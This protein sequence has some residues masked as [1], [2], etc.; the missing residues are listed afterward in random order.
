MLVL[1]TNR[2]H[3]RYSFLVSLLDRYFHVLMS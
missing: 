1:P 3:I 2:E